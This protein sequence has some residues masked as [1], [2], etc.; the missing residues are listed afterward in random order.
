MMAMTMA[1]GPDDRRAE[2]RAGREPAPGD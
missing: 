2:L 1:S